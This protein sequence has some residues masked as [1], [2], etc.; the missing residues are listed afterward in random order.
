MTISRCV[1]HSL[2]AFECETIQPKMPTPNS[3]LM[4]CISFPS[5]HHC[6]SVSNSVG[7]ANHG[8]VFGQE[9]LKALPPNTE[10]RDELTMWLCRAHNHVNRRIPWG[11]TPAHASTCQFSKFFKLVTFFNR[12]YVHTYSCSTKSKTAKSKLYCPC[13]FYSNRFKSFKKYYI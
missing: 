9:T 4:V 12:K 2:T 8:T 11:R 5:C 6:R 7:M 3:F 1:T 13:G 10:S